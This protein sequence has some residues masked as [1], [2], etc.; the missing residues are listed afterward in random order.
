MKGIYRASR[1]SH[2]SSRHLS[3]SIPEIDNPVEPVDPSYMAVLY[4][5]GVISLF[6]GV[7]CLGIVAD[8]RYIKWKGW[9]I[10]HRAQRVYALSPLPLGA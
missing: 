7:C 3:G 6:T 5:R 9:Q 10:V 8:D 4:F 1:G 2:Y